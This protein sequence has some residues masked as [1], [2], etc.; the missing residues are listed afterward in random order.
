MRFPIRGW[1]YVYMRV[2]LKGH[3]D[4]QLR[5][6]DSEMC[7]TYQWGKLHFSE[8]AANDDKAPPK[9][10][11]LV[12]IVRSSYACNWSATLAITREATLFQL[13]RLKF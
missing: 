5:R 10:C 8:I 4:A 9:E 2:L 13:Q 12:T 11:P 7:L 1:P 6:R 3:R